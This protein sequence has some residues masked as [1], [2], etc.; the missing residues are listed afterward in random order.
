MLSTIPALVFLICDYL[1]LSR[2]W[3]EQFLAIMPRYDALFLIEDS[4]MYGLVHAFRADYT[5]QFEA[6][7]QLLPLFVRIDW[8]S[9][10]LTHA[11]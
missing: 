1:P 10:W 8:L 9:F 6:R 3:Y 11:E 5:L 2:A 7:S 4:L